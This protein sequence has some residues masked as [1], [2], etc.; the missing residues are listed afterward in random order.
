MRPKNGS[1]YFNQTIIEMK[2]YESYLFP[3]FLLAMGAITLSGVNLFGA[4]ILE[5]AAWKQNVI[6]ALLIIFGM[7]PPSVREMKTTWMV[8]G[9]AL[10]FFMFGGANIIGTVGIML[11]LEKIVL[12][13]LV[14]FMGYRL[15][16]E[17]WR[18]NK[19]Y[20]IVPVLGL[21]SVAIL[22]PIQDQSIIGSSIDALT[23]LSASEFTSDKGFHIFLGLTGLSAGVTE[24]LILSKSSKTATGAAEVVQ[25]STG[26]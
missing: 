11:G 26:N 23:N 22:F 1:D 12:A 5:G 25:T 4:A 3:I 14:M 9:Y 24:L 20:M 15:W 17:T 19:L 21:V 7:L 6:F 10:A 18:I 16:S 2:N 13:V 8:A